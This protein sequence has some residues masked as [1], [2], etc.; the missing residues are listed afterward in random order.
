[1]RKRSMYDYAP[2]CATPH[3]IA[4]KMCEVCELKPGELLYD[5]G[6]G[7]GSIIITAAEEF[8]AKCIGIEIDKTLVMKTREKIKKKK[9]ESRVKVIHGDFFSPSFWAY[10]SSRKPKPYAIANA[11]VVT[12]YLLPHINNLLCPML[13]KE[14]KDGA[15]VVTRIF[16]M[17]KWKEI[18]EDEKIYLYKAGISFKTCRNLNYHTNYN[19]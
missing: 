7:D 5:L 14:L 19:L 12:L 17:D 10:K 2:F 8:G 4:R 3:E 11:D 16:K 6:S 15:R 18:R 1:M 13:E 9:L